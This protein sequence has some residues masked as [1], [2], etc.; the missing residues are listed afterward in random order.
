MRHAGWIANEIFLVH[1]KPANHASYDTCH[2]AEDNVILGCMGGT[3]TDI[4]KD[5]ETWAGDNAAPKVYWLSGMAG[6]GK[7]SIAHI[8]CERLHEKATLGG[9]LFCS[10]PDAA[11]S[12]WSRIIPTLANMLAESIPPIR[13]KVLENKPQAALLNTPFQ[14]FDLLVAGP[15]KSVIEAYFNTWVV[16]IDA[17]DEC[18]Q[19]QKVESLIPIICDRVSRLPLK[20]F[21]SS[22]PEAWIE[23]A[24]SPYVHTT[25]FPLHDVAE[26][27][28]RRDI[29]KFLRSSLSKVAQRFEGNIDWPSEQEPTPLLDQ[30]GR[31]L[32]Y[33][34]TVVRYIHASYA[35]H[36]QRLTVIMR[37]GSSSPLQMVFP[38]YGIRGNLWPFQVPSA[39]VGQVSIFPTSFRD[40][41]VDPARSKIYCVDGSESR[42]LLVN[43]CLRCLGRSLRHNICNSPED[44]I[45]SRPHLIND[46]SVIS[47]ALQYACL[48]WSS[49]LIRTLDDPPADPAHTLCLLSEFAD[50]HLVHWFEC[51]RAMEQ[52]ES[53]VRSFTKAWEAISVSVSC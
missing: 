12:D 42:Q 25:V 46:I 43:K 40:F 51:L 4:L 33:A 9:S 28:V 2:G 47:E 5:L 19:H 1:L 26:R 34:A 39:K 38:D 52:L 6:T 22:R 48:R 49:H 53:G 23:M 17:I 37:P 35:T 14:Q 10:R 3:R 27:D 41:I 24:S 20:F 29:E 7:P 50:E 30:S 18:S 21:T 8:L 16:V 31:L 11:L 15:A 13:S 36:R 32:I 45:G 44:T